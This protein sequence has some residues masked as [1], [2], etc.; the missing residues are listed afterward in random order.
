MIKD[1]L[2]HFLTFVDNGREDTFVDVVGEQW[3]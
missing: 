3:E 2:I 1:F